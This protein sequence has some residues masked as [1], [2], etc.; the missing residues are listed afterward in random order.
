MSERLYRR[1]YLALVEKHEPKLVICDDG[2]RF[3]SCSDPACEK[4]DADTKWR[5]FHQVA[6]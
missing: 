5:H 6:V 4:W 1:L 3:R 2:S